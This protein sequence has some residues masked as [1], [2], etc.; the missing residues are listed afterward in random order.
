MSELRHIAVIMDGNRRFAK[1]K[2]LMPGKG[3]EKGLE[4]MEDMIFNWV[5]HT[6]VKELTFYGLSIQNFKRNESEINFLL[7][8]FSKMLNDFLNRKANR[9]NS[10]NIKIK[11]IGRREMFSEEIQKKIKDLEEATKDNDNLTVN[12]AVAYGGR[13]EILDAINKAIT[14]RR[15]DAF[16][17]EEFSNS[18]ELKS[19]PEIVIRTG[20]GN[21]RTSNFLIW[22]TWYSEWFFVDKL[23]PE[24]TKE[25]LIDCIEKFSKVK[26]NFGR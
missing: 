4:I 2:F 12:L 3:H 14:F 25:D 16:T 5:N 1:E 9:L 17:M 8:L 24:F 21:T 22:Q 10:E 26:R 13:E 15:T 20:K 23:W 7:G 19:E 6:S 11:F 18:L